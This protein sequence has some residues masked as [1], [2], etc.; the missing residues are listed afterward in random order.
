MTECAKL[1]YRQNVW[2]SDTRMTESYD[3]RNIRYVKRAMQIFSVRTELITVI[4][5]LIRTRHSTNPVAV[6]CQSMFLFIGNI[7]AT[8][9]NLSDICTFHSLFAIE[10]CRNRISITVSKQEEEK[11]RRKIIVGLDKKSVSQVHPLA[12]MLAKSCCK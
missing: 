7:E 10:N 8:G 12:E 9:T 2:M 1:D 6:R 4:R 11:K 3:R 5:S